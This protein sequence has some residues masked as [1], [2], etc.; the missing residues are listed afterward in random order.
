M[1]RKLLRDL[2][3][4]RQ[5]NE[6]DAQPFRFARA[7][8]YGVVNGNGLFGKPEKSVVTDVTYRLVPLG[9]VFGEEVYE[10]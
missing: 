8:L 2:G 10:S 4:G 7:K 5:V 1:L 6:V 9:I 3:R